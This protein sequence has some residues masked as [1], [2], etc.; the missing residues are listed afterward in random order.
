MIYVYDN[1]FKDW[2]LFAKIFDEAGKFNAK[3]Y[4][5]VWKING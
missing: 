4:L 5:T 1:A 2:V 3:S